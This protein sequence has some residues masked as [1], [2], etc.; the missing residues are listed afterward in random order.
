MWKSR[1]M[2]FDFEVLVVFFFFPHPVA[3][4]QEGV[5]LP[6]S[7]FSVGSQVKEEREKIKT[8]KLT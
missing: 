8:N 6:L 4:L 1:I 2:P 7:S 3:Q 5:S